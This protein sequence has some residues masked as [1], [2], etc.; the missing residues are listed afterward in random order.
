MV[1]MDRIA[2]VG[3][4]NQLPHRI[5]VGSFRFGCSHGVSFCPAET[6]SMSLC[7]EEHG[8]PFGNVTFLSSFVPSYDGQ[9]FAS[10]P[11]AAQYG[12]GDPVF[13]GVRLGR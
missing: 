9:S 7:V 5:P 6:V 13:S 12:N 4:P 10:R 1:Y 11:D 8:V 2:T 3:A